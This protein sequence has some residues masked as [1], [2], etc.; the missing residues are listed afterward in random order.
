MRYSGGNK[1]FIKKQNSSDSFAKCKINNHF[2]I[3]QCLPD[4]GIKKNEQTHKIKTYSSEKIFPVLLLFRMSLSRVIE[5]MPIF[6]FKNIY[7][8][9][10]WH[11]VL[12]CLCRT[13]R[14]NHSG[15]II[16]FNT[17]LY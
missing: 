3:V 2:Y 15:S 4:F 14:R 12:L 9:V 7:L 11:F 1:C 13:L 17:P 8:T 16:S 5:S 10:K 6:F